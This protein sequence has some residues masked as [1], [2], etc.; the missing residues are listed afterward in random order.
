MPP[1]EKPKVKIIITEQRRF[2]DE[3]GQLFGP[4]EWNVDPAVSIRL[5]ANGRAKLAN[6]P[7]TKAQAPKDPPKPPSNPRIPPVKESEGEVGATPLPEG[8]PSQATLAVAGYSTVE[9]L[10]VPDIKEKL[11]AVEGL[12]GA[13]ITKIGLA[14]SKV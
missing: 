1:I 4:G 13:E 14:I 3:G 10:K 12:T 6:P 9:S 11:Q 8:F 7:A 2:T 5:I